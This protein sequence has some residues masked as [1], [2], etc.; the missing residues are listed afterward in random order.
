[1]FDESPRAH[2]GELSPSEVVACANEPSA[3][4]KKK[5][6]TEERDESASERRIVSALLK[7]CAPTSEEA[8]ERVQTLERRYRILFVETLDPRFLPQGWTVDHLTTV[9]LRPPP[10]ETP[11]RAFANGRC[12]WGGTCKY[13]H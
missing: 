11:C 7:G 2:L 10:S 6:K 8:R 9:R 5:K 13:R 1:M 12:A 4:S 3:P